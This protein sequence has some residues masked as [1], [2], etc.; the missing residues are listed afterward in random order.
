MSTAALWT[1]TA[2]PLW[3][4]TWETP[5]WRV[6]GTVRAR[7]ER[8][9][10]GGKGLNV[11]RVAERLGCPA[12]ALL[13][14]GGDAGGSAR[15]WLRARGRGFLEFP[16]EAGTRCGLVVRAEGLEETSFLGPDVP[17]DPGACDAAAALLSGV[18][19]DDWVAVC[20]S[21]PG[22]APGSME[23]LA[24]ALVGRAAGNLVVDSYGPFL[25]WAATLP[26]AALKVNRSELCGLVGAPPEGAVLAQ[27]LREAARAHPA[28]RVW[29][30]TD[31]SAGAWWWEPGAGDAPAHKAAPPVARPGSLTGAGDAFLAGVLSARLLKGLPWASAVEAGLQV[32]GRKVA[33]LETTEFPL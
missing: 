27:V 31:G 22:F 12:T 8:V 15:A 2:N 23:A 25:A 21:V 26:L 9:Q 18:P 7:V 13:P 11:A 29:I 20:G 33:S 3:E 17:L 10:L 14:L 19:A 6:G 16:Q 4:T 24:R 1:F 32:A 28:V 30:V 5:A